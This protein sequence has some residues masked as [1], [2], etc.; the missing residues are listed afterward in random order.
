MFTASLLVISRNLERKNTCLSMYELF[1]K[2]TATYLYH[3]KLIISR[4]EL[5]NQN[6][7][8][9]KNMYLNIYCCFMLNSQIVKEKKQQMS[10]N[11]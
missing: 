4:K 6:L 5:S 1:L 3:G 7:H 9:H 8:L 2:K 11:R 10:L